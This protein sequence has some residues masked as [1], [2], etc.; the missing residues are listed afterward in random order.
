[1]KRMI[2]LLAAALL[3]LMLCGCETGAGTQHT[4][5]PKATANVTGSPR[6]TATPTPDVTSTPDVTPTPDV[7]ETPDVTPDIPDATETPTT[8]TPD[9]PTGGESETGTNSGNGE[10]PQP[11]R[12]GLM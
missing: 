6:P 12:G 8:E 2:L 4:N 9:S 10:V 11:R 7:T 3:A 1:M 5:P